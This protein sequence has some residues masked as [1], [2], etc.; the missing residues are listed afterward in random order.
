MEEIRML[1]ISLFA[2][3]TVVFVACYAYS[4]GSNP[5]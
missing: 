1:F 4:S 2:V 3:F 5:R